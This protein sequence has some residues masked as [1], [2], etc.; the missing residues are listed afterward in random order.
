MHVPGR[1]AFVT[2]GASG[3]GMATVVTLAKRGASIVFIDRDKDGGRQTMALAGHSDNV[4]FRA[5][6]VTDGKNLAVGSAVERFGRLDIVAN[7]AGIGDGDLFA[8]DAGLGCVSST[9]T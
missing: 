6:D 3:I 4:V 8:D 9:S 5:C 7:I 1:V 2:G